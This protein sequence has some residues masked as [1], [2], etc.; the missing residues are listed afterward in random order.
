MVKIPDP[1]REV[2]LDVGQQIELPNHVGV[3]LLRDE[4]ESV[5]F[6][7]PV[8]SVELGCQVWWGDQMGCHGP[9]IV[10]GLVRRGG[11]LLL[12]LRHGGVATAIRGT[13]ILGI[14]GHDA[15][16]EASKEAADAFV[17]QD[18]VGFGVASNR[19]RR[20]LGEREEDPADWPFEWEW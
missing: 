13:S 17:I 5:R 6:V 1:D 3:T 10:K 14:D 18:W 9:A 15:I 19:I 20:M 11:P 8:C 7:G 12:L 16:V 4:N 2:R